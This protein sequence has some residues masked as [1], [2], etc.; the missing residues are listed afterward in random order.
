MVRGAITQ[1]RTDAA[2]IR[3]LTPVH[4]GIPEATDRLVRYVQTLYPLLGEFLPE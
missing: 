3:V 4:A 2:L 1:N